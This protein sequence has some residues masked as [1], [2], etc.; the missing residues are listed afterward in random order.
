VASL[1]TLLETG[2]PCLRDPRPGGYRPTMTYPLSRI[3]STASAAYGVYALAQ[4]SHL[5]QALHSDLEDQAGLE[6]LGRTYGVR[7]TAIS[8]L[9]IL[10]RSDK[11]VRSSMLLRI[12]NDLGDAAVLGTRTEDP[13][14]RRKVLAVT[15]GWAA[16]NAVALAIDTRRS[17]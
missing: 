14:I 5:W 11:T 6:L 9:G 1:E 12:A 2:E 15:L 3:M 10:G 16:L 7:D 8:T 17:R 4:P 13:D